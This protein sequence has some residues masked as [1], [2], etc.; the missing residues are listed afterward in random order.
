MSS[1]QNKVDNDYSFLIE[2]TEKFSESSDLFS[3]YDL[4]N[5][6]KE[7]LTY[8]EREQLLYSIKKMI[9][10]TNLYSKWKSSTIKGLLIVIHFCLMSSGICAIIINKD[11][12]NEDIKMKM[13]LIKMF[14]INLIIIPFWIFSHFY[15]F[16]DS[17]I[18][19]NVM[20][21]LGSFIL[22]NDSETNNF[23]QYNLQKDNFS[24]CV[25]KKNCSQKNKPESLKKKIIDKPNFI[26][27]VI[28]VNFDFEIDKLL[29]KNIIPQEDVNVMVDLDSFMS[30]ELKYRFDKFVHECLVPSL[31]IGGMYIL[32]GS[33]KNY[34]VAVGITL[35]FLL[36]FLIFLI[37]KQLKNK[38]KKK[39]KKYIDGLNDELEKK[40]KFVYVYKNL[41]MFFTL[42]EKGKNLSREKIIRY[43]NSIILN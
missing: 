8:P 14:L 1:Y 26:N 40:G 15:F 9:L 12:I 18:I 36:C 37:Q 3:V 25:T 6:K 11:M 30:K 20:Y 33:K 27:Y 43:I 21:N 23:F 16:K 41:L 32:F 29:F 24:I 35:A 17:E 28:N 2:R 38:F 39:F 7:N 22:Q 4:S 19:Q 42:N 5:L 31:L 34:F 13:F 10:S